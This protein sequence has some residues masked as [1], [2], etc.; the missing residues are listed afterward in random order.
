MNNNLPFTT[1]SL[2]NLTVVQSKLYSLD[3]YF[4]IE[5]LSDM[6]LFANLFTLVSLLILILNRPQLYALL[7]LV[8][9]LFGLALD[10][11]GIWRRI[12]RYVWDDDVVSPD[13]ASPDVASPDVASP[14][15]ASPDVASPDAHKQQTQTVLET[16]LGD[17]QP[18]GRI[19]AVCTSRSE[20]EKKMVIE[21]FVAAISWIHSLGS[22]T[23]R[24][25][26]P[27]KLYTK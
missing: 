16:H 20:K 22:G 18:H 2:E 3:F 15:V 24:F 4:Q 12:F 1:L 26:F 23:M 11:V 27:K 5:V 6:F 9:C 10:Y 14:D 8:L 21:I 19:A 13:V 17:L 25:I 7:S